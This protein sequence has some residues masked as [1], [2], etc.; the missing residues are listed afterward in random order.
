MNNLE[1]WAAAAAKGDSKAFENLYTATNRT[2]YFTCLSFVKSEADASDIVSDTYLTAFERISTL[3]DKGKVQAWLVRIAVNK[4][5]DFLKKQKPDYVDDEQLANIAPEEDEGF[6]PDVYVTEAEK[7]RIVMKIMREALSDNLYQTV[8]MYYFDEMPVSE[9]AEMMDCPVGTVTYRLSAARSKIKEG[10]L[11]YEKENNDKLHAAMGL[12]LLTRIFR[13]EAESLEIPKITLNLPINAESSVSNLANQAQNA[14]QKGTEAMTNSLKIKV[15]AGVAAVA[16]VGGVGAA[17]VFGGNN[18]KDDDDD[19]RRVTNSALSSQQMGEFSEEEEKKNGVTLWIDTLDFSTPINKNPD[20]TMYGGEGQ[21]ISL[22]LD[23]EALS[24]NYKFNFHS[25][26]GYFDIFEEAVYSEDRTYH[27]SIGVYPKSEEDNCFRIDILSWEETDIEAYEKN[28]LSVSFI[29]EKKLLDAEG[30]LPESA[31]QKELLDNFIDKVGSPNYLNFSI[32]SFDAFQ[33]TRGEVDQL[34]G[35]IIGWV[36]DD[37]TIFVDLFDWTFKG[38]DDIF[39][40]YA[41]YVT[42]EVFDVYMT[43]IPAQHAQIDLSINDI[44]RLAESNGTTAPDVA[45]K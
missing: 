26:D 41:W 29:D 8:V 9:I 10:V 28:Y 13:A 35:Y 43:D 33:S 7:R 42:P 25:H 6:L 5:R 14:A 17:L 12:P 11:A 16:V 20:L 31:T 1:N 22:P 27:D 38:Y 32:S 2:V 30:T 21:T 23:V 34:N 3:E 15:I 19:D 40:N 37:Y 18:E 45:G 44:E 4:C 24:E 36:F 39:I